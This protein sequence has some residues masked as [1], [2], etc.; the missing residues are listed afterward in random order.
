MKKS[1]ILISILCLLISNTSF[2]NVQAQTITSNTSNNSSLG[3]TVATASANTSENNSDSGNSTESDANTTTDTE[4]TSDTT[5]TATPQEDLKP[6]NV[7]D[8]PSINSQSAVVMEAST[9][10]ILYAKNMHDKHYPASITK[11]LTT[12]V[13]LENSSPGE[14]VT[15]SKNAIYDVDLDSSRI[16]IDVGEKLTMEQSLYAVMLESA[17][18]VAYG[19][20]EHI[21]GSV[22]AFT[23][24]MNKTAKNLGCVDSNFVNPH[25]LPDENHYTSAYDMA[26][27]SRAAINNETFRKITGTKTYAIP[28]TNIQSETR[29]L[30]NHH[31]MVKGSIS[32]DGVIGGKTGYTSKAKY[33]L[34]TF[35]K[36]NGMTLISVIMCCDSITDEYADT[37]ALLNY[38]FENY[39]LYN[40]SQEI[41]PNNGD[42]DSMFTKYAPLFSRKT[43][44]L[45]LSTEGSVVLPKGISFDKAEKTISY[46]PVAELNDGSNVIGT[47]NFTYKNIFVGYADILYNKASSP[48]MLNNT[49]IP[50]TP[51]TI[52]TKGVQ[53][54]SDSDNNHRLRFIIISIIVVVILISAICYLLF[55]EL[56]YRKRRNAYTA[57][58]KRSGSHRRNNY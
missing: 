10:A 22:P 47:M 52:V 37:K 3:S 16:G 36:R 33:T 11:I 44:S 58:K 29:Y 7:G 51:K 40:I 48:F 20:A 26:L 6:L 46:K 39:S 56:P 28:P 30:A 12:L 18:E 24:L 55:V 49:F 35:A 53:M 32:Y 38:G 34:V 21:A 14:V 57:K 5:D 31:K 54:P 19:V 4:K 15:F 1:L 41:D 9:G 45:K 23:A 25:G 27:I 43:S 17:N 2:T 8:K 50:E 42:T 13:A